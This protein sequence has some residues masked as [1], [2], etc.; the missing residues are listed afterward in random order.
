MVGIYV[1][2]IW[3]TIGVAVGAEFGPGV[4]RLGVGAMSHRFGPRSVGST[5]LG[6]FIQSC[7]HAAV[8]RLP[9]WLKSAATV[10]PALPIRWQLR[11]PFSSIKFLTSASFNVPVNPG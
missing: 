3:N 5:A 6:F 1:V 4:S 2:F 8:R 7:N 11:Q 9:T 10:P